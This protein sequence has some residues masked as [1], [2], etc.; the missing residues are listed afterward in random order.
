MQVFVVVSDPGLDAWVEGVFS[1]RERAEEFISGFEE[2][3]A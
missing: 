2:P 1:T 3:L